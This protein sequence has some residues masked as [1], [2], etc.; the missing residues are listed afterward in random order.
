[1]A[2]RLLPAFADCQSILAAFWHIKM[3]SSEIWRFFLPV[4]VCN[5][6]IMAIR[7]VPA[8]ADCQSILASFLHIKKESCQIGITSRL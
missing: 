2:I 7:L 4:F 8:F 3:C 5:S 6:E 1:M